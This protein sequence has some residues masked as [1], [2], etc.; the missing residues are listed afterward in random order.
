MGT[1]A[2]SDISPSN[3]EAGW[4]SSVTRVN[5]G[6]A[7]FCPGTCVDGVPLHAAKRNP[8]LNTKVEIN[9]IFKYRLIF[10]FIFIDNIRSI[11]G[12]SQSGSWTGIQNGEGL[13]HFAVQCSGTESE[14]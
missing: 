8:K 11:S 2:L 13:P 10:G 12:S 14:G 4:G 9:K 6:V 7:I 5:D 3:V 1:G